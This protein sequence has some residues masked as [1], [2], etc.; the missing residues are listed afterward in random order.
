MDLNELPLDF[1]FDFLGVDAANPSLC[2]QAYLATAVLGS[3][4]HD[5]SVN[6]S[7]LL[8]EKSRDFA[9]TNQF[10]DASAEFAD[11]NQVHD[12]PNTT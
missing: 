6:S 8:K 2:T 4:D 10:H 11:I 1:D 9:D 5:Q 3:Y 7:T 12:V